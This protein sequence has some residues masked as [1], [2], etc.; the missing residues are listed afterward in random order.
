MVYLEKM[1]TFSS[2]QF[3][4]SV[5]LSTDNV[6]LGNE[7]KSAGKL[8][9]SRNNNYEDQTCEINISRE[10]LNEGL[11]GLSIVCKRKNTFSYWPYTKTDVSCGGTAPSWAHMEMSFFKFSAYQRPNA[12]MSS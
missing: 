7:L 8:T 9:I 12:I 10:R 1:S 3:K 5:F 11:G 2:F 6:K 4:E